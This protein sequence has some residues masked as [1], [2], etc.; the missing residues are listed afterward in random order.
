[1]GSIPTPGT[2]SQ[3]SA[4]GEPPRSIDAAA[5]TVTGLSSVTQSKDGTPRSTSPVT[6]VAPE[7]ELWPF[8]KDATMSRMA[9]RAALVAVLSA[10]IVGAGQLPGSVRVRAPEVPEGTGAL[11][12]AASRV[13]PVV[14]A[15]RAPSRPPEQD[16]AAQQ[17]EVPEE[18]QAAELNEPGG[19]TAARN[20]PAREWEVEL[21]GLWLG[22][23][24][25][26]TPLPASVPIDEP[27]TFDHE[28][29]RGG[30]TPAPVVALDRVR[31]LAI[32][33]V[34]VPRVPP[35]SA[36]LRLPPGVSVAPEA[37]G[38]IYVLEVR[39]GVEG[40]WIVHNDDPS[41]LAVP[42]WSDAGVA[43]PGPLKPPPG[44]LVFDLEGMF[45]GVTLEAGDRLAIV[46]AR[47]VLA[48]VRRMRDAAAAELARPPQ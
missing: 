20:E 48:A 4:R 34:T 35:D 10:G 30:W 42:G 23:D 7:D 5:A 39:P 43:M 15:L 44:A 33:R 29:V 13:R 40:G 46:T 45:A 38:T 21:T 26:L 28:A 1:M 2:N 47:H 6:A 3:G 24:L 11:T 17:D 8:G 41:P 19:G 16:E 14:F 18:D 36:Y 22:D 31:R 9:L 37:P 25:V 12:F 27:L 32:V